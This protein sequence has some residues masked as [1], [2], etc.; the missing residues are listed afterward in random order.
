M[1]V[2]RKVGRKTTTAKK[3]IRNA[4]VKKKAGPN[5]A[6]TPKKTARKKPPADVES[7][8][9][10][11]SNR[12]CCL[13]FGLEHDDGEK[14][15]Q[16]AHLDGNRSNS[17]ESNL[18]YLC[19]RHHTLYDSTTSQHKKYTPGE[20][21]HYRSDLYD[22]VAAQRKAAKERNK[23]QAELERKDAE[24]KQQMAHKMAEMDLEH[25]KKSKEQH[26]EQL[27]QMQEEGVLQR[28]RMMER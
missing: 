20:V 25:Q 18:A 12:R 2:K 10:I 7:S 3:S 6:K 4:T 11:K 15:G 13:C 17:R 22:H 24:H 8:V 27:K 26:L 28:R 14:E 19:L 23:W 9:L 5:V 16:I 1:G 21:K